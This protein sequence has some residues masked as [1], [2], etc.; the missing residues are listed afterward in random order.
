[1]VSITPR[2]GQAGQSGIP[3]VPSGSTSPPQSPPLAAYAMVNEKRSS[4]PSSSV[5]ARKGGAAYIITEECERLF[6]ETLKAIFLG[7]RNLASQDS[8]VMGMPFNSHQYDPHVRIEQNTNSVTLRNGS[9]DLSSSRS[10]LDS[11]VDQHGLVT[12][13]LEIWDY[14]G[15][16]RFRGFIA[17][18]RGERAMFI[19]F[20]KGVFGSDLKPGLMALLELCN[21]ADFDCSRLLVCLDRRLHPEDLKGLMRDLGWVGFE[22]VT[23]N[24]W[25]QD[26]E[27]VSDCWVFL[28]MDA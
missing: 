11:F 26:K 15:G 12:D 19:F 17:E 18:S 20:D 27:I 10:S 24:D 1:M 6:C 9:F 14:I 13:W 22:P 3:E 7:E 25:T 2:P 21:V 28:N 5:M 23:L 8:L 4:T 16:A